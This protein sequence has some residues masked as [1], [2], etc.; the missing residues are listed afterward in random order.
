ML[1]KGNAVN[2]NEIR[3]CQMKVLI[4]FFYK[5]PL[6]LGPTLQY[7]PAAVFLPV[8]EHFKGRVYVNLLPGCYLRGFYDIIL[9]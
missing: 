1:D 3:V 7:L 8:R 9:C 2:L 5:R 4:F 6:H